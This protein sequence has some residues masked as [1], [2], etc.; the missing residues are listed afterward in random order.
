MTKPSNYRKAKSLQFV[1]VR[2]MNL[3]EETYLQHKLIH[4]GLRQ[5]LVLK[6]LQQDINSLTQ[7][8]RKLLHQQA[9]EPIATVDNTMRE[10]WEGR[11]GAGGGLRVAWHHR[12]QHHIHSAPAPRG[13]PVSAKAVP[14]GNGNGKSLR[15]SRSSHSASALT[16]SPMGLGELGDAGADADAGG[17]LSLVQLRDMAC[18]NSISERE[19]ASQREWRRQERERLKRAEREALRHKMQAFFQ[20]LDNNNV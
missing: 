9:C 8:H 13:P 10:I 18:I 20:T 12:R 7:E 19:L 5:R 17:A 6:L 4:I 1:D 15:R 16:L 14:P 11:G 2:Q 3:L